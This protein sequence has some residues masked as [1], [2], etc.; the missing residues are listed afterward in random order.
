MIEA[1]LA[2]ALS[3]LK[4]RILELEVAANVTGLK[5]G[6]LAAA[7]RDAIELLDVDEGGQ[8]VPRKD[9]P[10]TL[11]TL[12]AYLR[13]SSPF[14]FTDTGAGAKVPSSKTIRWDDGQALSQN[15]EAVADGT[16]GIA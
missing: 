5:P 16:V 12:A 1:K 9:G 14:Y 8:V 3:A 13:K 11:S 4:R 6:A 10:T 7:Q 2:S 15:L